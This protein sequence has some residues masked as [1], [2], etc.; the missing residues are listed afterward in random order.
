M[1]FLEIEPDK[2]DLL[3]LVGLGIQ[4]YHSRCLRKCGSMRASES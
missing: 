3:R 2:A 4:E 1:V